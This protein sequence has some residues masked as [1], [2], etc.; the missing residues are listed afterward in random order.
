MNF[1]LGKTFL[2][3]PMS[4]NHREMEIVNKKMC[5]KVD[6]YKILKIFVDN[7]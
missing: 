4:Q 1:S 2:L 3:M 7:F 6:F 5:Q